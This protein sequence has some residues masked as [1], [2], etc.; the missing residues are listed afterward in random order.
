[1][2][3]RE[4][5]K[6]AIRESGSGVIF[7]HNHPSGDSSPSRAD[8][9]LTERLKKSGEILGIRVLDH[10]IVGEDVY[11]SFADEELL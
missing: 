4:V 9:M 6:E 8:I 11:Y 1:V 2:H 7:I 3:P 5:F 10:I